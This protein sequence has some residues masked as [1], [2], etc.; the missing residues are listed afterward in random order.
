MIRTA[1]RQHLADRIAQ[2]GIAGSADV[3]AYSPGDKHTTAEMI[4]GDRTTGSVTFP[5]GMASP[6]IQRD[7]FSV[8][9][10]VRVTARPDVADA[11]A[12]CDELANHVATILADDASLLGFEADGERVTDT[13]PDG[14]GIQVDTREG[15]NSKGV[16][17]ALAEITVPIE[18]QTLNTES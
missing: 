14:Q 16:T 7:Q 17:L 15:E 11:M 3:S 9:F 12:R 6:R 10:V 1:V 5:Y 4:F 18:T 13:N 2:S 8:V